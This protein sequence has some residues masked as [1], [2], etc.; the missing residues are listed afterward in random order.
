MLRGLAL[1][2]RHGRAAAVNVLHSAVPNASSRCL[3][4]LG[5]IWTQLNLRERNHKADDRTNQAKLDIRGLIAALKWKIRTTDAQ[6]VSG[7]YP[8]EPSSICS[9][10]STTSS[11]EIA[12]RTFSK[13]CTQLGSTAS[14]TACE[15]GSIVATIE[16][17]G[18]PA[19]FCAL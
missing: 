15:A 9:A 13:G 8:T 17:L 10:V 11:G 4:L 7:G 18:A 16:L 5:C 1:D 3:G 12:E 14:A 2:E 19:A 6:R